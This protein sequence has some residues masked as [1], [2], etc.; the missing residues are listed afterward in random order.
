MPDLPAIV[1]IAPIGCTIM[2]TG[3]NL[4]HRIWLEIDVN[5]YSAVK[6]LVIKLHMTDGIKAQHCSLIYPN[7]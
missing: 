5:V 3:K 6:S 1:W 7:S 2:I 4:K